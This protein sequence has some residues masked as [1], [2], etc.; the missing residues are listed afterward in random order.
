MKSWALTRVRTAP[1][2]V[3]L[4]ADGL[5]AGGGSP[6]QRLQGLSPHLVVNVLREGTSGLEPVHLGLVLGVV[7]HAGHGVPGTVHPA[8]DGEGVE[9]TPPVN[10]QDHL[11]HGGVGRS[12]LEPVPAGPPVS[13]PSSISHD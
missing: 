7:S 13:D 1:G 8:E 9:G 2:L 3:T 5:L 11:R 10:I 6:H 12:G 4:V